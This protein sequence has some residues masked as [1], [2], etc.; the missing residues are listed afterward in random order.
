[1]TNLA[2]LV[3]NEQKNS[4]NSHTYVYLTESF[5]PPPRYD[6]PHPK[7]SHGGGGDRQRGPDQGRHGVPAG[8]EAEGGCRKVGQVEGGGGGQAG[9]AHRSKDAE[10]WK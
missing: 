9:H 2:S 6:D 5:P 8:V 7:A 4:V 3:L 1:M 10:D